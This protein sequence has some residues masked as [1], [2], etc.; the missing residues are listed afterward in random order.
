MGAWWAPHGLHKRR[1]S[2]ILVA[3]QQGGAE[4]HTLLPV[5]DWLRRGTALC[6]PNVGGHSC[7]EA[8]GPVAVACS[9][10]SKCLQSANAF[11]R[12]TWPNSNPIGSFCRTT[13]GSLVP[14]QTVL[15][16]LVV[17]ALPHPLVFTCFVAV[18]CKL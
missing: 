2:R 4:S 18:I 1:Q 15:L 7:C 13:V 3:V 16:S 9:E 14:Q 10:K 17:T 8:V 12:V 5:R 6:R 11:S